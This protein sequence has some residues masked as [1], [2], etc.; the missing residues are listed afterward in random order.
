M[1]ENKKTPFI[2]TMQKNAKKILIVEDDG[3][4]L[5]TLAKRFRDEG[6]FVV[7][8]TNGEDA[9]KRIAEDTP[10]LILLDLVIPLVDGMSVLRELRQSEKGKK[11]LVI[12]LTNLSASEKVAEAIS[13]D[14][15]DYLI[16]SDWKLENLV[17]KVKKYFPEMK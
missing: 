12:L 10:D 4:V 9:Q 8:A 16:K 17:Q 1:G 15:Y 7:T 2:R 11:V 13:Y 5:E 14:V 6:F 3:L